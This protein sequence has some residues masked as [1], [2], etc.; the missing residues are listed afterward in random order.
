L[1]L[2]SDLAEESVSGVVK[3][4]VPLETRLL[5]DLATTT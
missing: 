1:I 3:Y 2:K 4:E 5:V